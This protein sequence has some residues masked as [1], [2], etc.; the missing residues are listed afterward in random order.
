MLSKKEQMVMQY[1]YEV[2]TAKKNSCIL[3]PLDIAHAVQP[4]YDLKEIEMN[5]KAAENTAPLSEEE[6]AAIIAHEIS[7]IQL[8]H[9][10][11]AIKKK[12]LA[13]GIGVSAIGSPIGKI[14]TGAFSL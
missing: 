12:L 4:K 1:I 9:S 13:K 11:K 10:I 7:H 3:S 6:L 8:E 14:K 5:L 2:S